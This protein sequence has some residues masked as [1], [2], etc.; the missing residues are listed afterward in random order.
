MIEDFEEYTVDDN[1]SQLMDFLMDDQ[2][3]EDKM[4]ME[5]HEHITLHLQMPQL[6]VDQED[7]EPANIHDNEP[8]S[9]KN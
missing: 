1:N 2:E 5:F 3:W 7:N 8:Q 9:I 4:A 6:N